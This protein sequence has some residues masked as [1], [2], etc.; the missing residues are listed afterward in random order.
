[1]N[2]KKNPKTKETTSEK[3]LH[4]AI[5]EEFRRVKVCYGESWQLKEEEYICHGCEESNCVKTCF[6]ENEIREILDHLN[7]KCDT[8]KRW[9][10]KVTV[11]SL[12]K[13]YKKGY[14]ATQIKAVIDLKAKEWKDNKTMKY[15]LRPST[16]FE[17]SNFKRYLKQTS[18][19]N[20]K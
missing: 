14:N 5:T 4:S 2:S 7:E 12:N 1:M 3:H 19:T 9:N 8:R 20:P 17:L 13:L 16:L 6:C 15:F 18:L 10:A 11:S